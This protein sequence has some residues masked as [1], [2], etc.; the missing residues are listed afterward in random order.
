MGG[1]VTEEKSIARAQYLDLVYSQLDTLYEMLLDAPRPSSYQ[2]TSKS[3]DMPLVDGVIGSE[4]QTPVKYSSKQKLVSNTG[5]NDPSQNSP[6]PGKT[7]EVHAMQSTTMDKSSKG[8]KKG[9]EKAKD[10]ALKQGPPK[11]S[12][13]DASQI[14]LKY[15]CLICDEGHY[16]KDC[17]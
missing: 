6:S 9:K 15:P 10:D 1:C 2:A 8:K 12:S 17:P 13:N 4:S 5:S 11:S 16:T 14:K 7:C 3:L